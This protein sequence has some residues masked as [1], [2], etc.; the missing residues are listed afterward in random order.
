MKLATMLDPLDLSTI[1]KLKVKLKRQL[2]PFQFSVF[3][4]R[5][6]RDFNLG[7][8]YPLCCKHLIAGD[9]RAM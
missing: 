6:C 1:F 7:S 4:L 2:K 3:H 9:L 5:T 8:W